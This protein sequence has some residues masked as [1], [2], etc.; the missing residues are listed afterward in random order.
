MV[1]RKI[2]VVREMTKRNNVGL[3]VVED[4]KKLMQHMMKRWDAL[5]FVQ[6][7]GRFTPE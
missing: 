7:K 3:V 6:H 1:D 2:H 4:V 5:E